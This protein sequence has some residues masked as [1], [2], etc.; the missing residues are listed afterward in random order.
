MNQFWAYYR[1]RYYYPFLDTKGLVTAANIVKPVYQHVFPP[2]LAPSLSFV[3][4]LHKVTLLWIQFYGFLGLNFF[5]V[6]HMTLILNLW[7]PNNFFVN[8][9]WYSY[10]NS[11]FWVN[12]TTCM[13]E[14]NTLMQWFCFKDYIW[15]TIVFKC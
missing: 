13:R 1:Y 3:G 5:I 9:K 8:C 11:R 14:K 15:I 4:L 10:P 7:S 6:W 12:R 2:S